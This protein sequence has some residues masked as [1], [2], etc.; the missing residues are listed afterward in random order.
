[1]IHLYCILVFFLLFYFFIFLL[2]SFFV[3][4]FTNE[5]SIEFLAQILLH[6]QIIDILS[7]YLSINL[8]SVNIG[9][10]LVQTLFTFSSQCQLSALDLE[11]F[12]QTCG[13]YTLSQN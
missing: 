3:M 9:K 4:F 2:L 13:I 12:M 8:P 1:M 6:S 11:W 5:F 7:H 10:L